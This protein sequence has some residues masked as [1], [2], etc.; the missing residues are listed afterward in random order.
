L[1]GKLLRSSIE[2]SLALERMRGRLLLILFFDVDRGVI[3]TSGQTVEMLV[4]IDS[5]RV[6]SMMK[7][8]MDIKSTRSKKSGI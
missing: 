3:V 5:L 6:N 1:I 4:K 8:D 7:G 2:I